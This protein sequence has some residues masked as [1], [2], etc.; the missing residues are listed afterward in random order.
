MEDND[1]LQGWMRSLLDDCKDRGLKKHPADPSVSRTT[2][3]AFNISPKSG[4]GLMLSMSGGF[5]VGHGRLRMFGSPAQHT[6]ARSLLAWNQTIGQDPAQSYLLIADDIYGN[7]YAINVRMPG[8]F[9]PGEIIASFADNGGWETASESFI[10]FFS[11]C[12]SGDLASI[13]SDFETGDTTLEQKAAEAAEHV[14]NFY[15]PLFTKEGSI[16]GSSK[17]VVPAHEEFQMRMQL[18]GIGA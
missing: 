7:F 11:Y 12:L 5:S 8:N 4:L 16:K 1:G 9:R 6:N 14:I 17:A 2:M 10:D 13:F 3:E 18:L 15:P